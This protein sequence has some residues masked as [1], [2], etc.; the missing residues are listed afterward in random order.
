MWW[1]GVA[2]FVALSTV[3][4]LARLFRRH[5]LLWILSISQ[6][7][8]VLFDAVPAIAGADLPL[9]GGPFTGLSKLRPRIW[10]VPGR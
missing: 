4:L 8:D 6:L 10:A 1:R 5:P 3:L 9:S 7:L 2:A